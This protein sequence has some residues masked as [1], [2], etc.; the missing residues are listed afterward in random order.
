MSQAEIMDFLDKHPG[1]YYCAEELKLEFKDQ[2]NNLALQRSLK[3]IIKREEY[4]CK[5]LTGGPGR[6]GIQLVYRAKKIKE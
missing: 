4:E 5:L 1:R 6:A 3:Q 2:F